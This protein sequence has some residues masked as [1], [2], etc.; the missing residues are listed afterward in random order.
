[1]FILSFG[2]RSMNARYITQ[3]GCGHACMKVL[4]KWKKAVAFTGVKLIWFHGLGNHSLGEICQPEQNHRFRIVLG[5]IVRESHASMIVFWAL[6]SRVTKIS[7]NRNV[8]VRNYS[9]KIWKLSLAFQ[10]YR[11]TFVLIYYVQTTWAD[12]FL[13]ICIT[14]IQSIALR[15]QSLEKK[16][17]KIKLYNI[18]CLNQL[19]AVTKINSSSFVCW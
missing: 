7:I 8:L 1:M 13:I 18:A 17:L 6:H 10:L 16:S 12:S 5:S 3:C 11:I 9:C 14:H 2:S 4:E 19:S 15:Q